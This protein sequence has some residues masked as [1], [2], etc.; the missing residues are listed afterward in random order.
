MV[1]TQLG[2]TLQRAWLEAGP[3]CSLD[4]PADRMLRPASPREATPAD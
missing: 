4:L 3:V 1:K 2:G